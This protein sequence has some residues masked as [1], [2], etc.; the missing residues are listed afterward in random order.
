[1]IITKQYDFGYSFGAAEPSGTPPRI[2]KE[3]QGAEIDNWIKGYNQAV[4]DRS[5]SNSIRRSNL[6]A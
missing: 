6:G 4:H 2:P 1:M 3:L 5:I